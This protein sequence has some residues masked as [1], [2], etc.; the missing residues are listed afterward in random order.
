M[1]FQAL[2]G[3]ILVI[4]Q[5][6]AV[7]SHPV[8]A[9]RSADNRQSMDAEVG[10]KYA[11]VTTDARDA[12]L[13]SKNSQRDE[14]YPLVSSERLEPSVDDQTHSDTRPRQRVGI[15]SENAP[16]NT[17]TTN[18]VVRPGPPTWKRTQ[19]AS[20]TVRPGPPTWKRG[21]ILDNEPGPPTW[22]RAKDGPKA[23]SAYMESEVETEKQVDDVEV[24]SHC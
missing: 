13:N 15:R 18:M 2:L 20:G 21:P 7:T 10:H 1:K 17:P 9:Q 11:S 22:K 4:V 16:A 5:V 8:A 3:Y 14:G 19:I 23:G 6:V 12:Q 24:A